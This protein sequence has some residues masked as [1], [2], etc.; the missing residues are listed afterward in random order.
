MVKLKEDTKTVRS[1]FIMSAMAVLFILASLIITLF[2][3]MPNSEIFSLIFSSLIFT[4]VLFVFVGLFYLGKNYK[5]TFLMKMAIVGFSLYL[6]LFI[7]ASHYPSDYGQRF[8]EFNDTITQRQANLEELIRLNV[9]EEVTNSL[10]L[11]TI[12]YILNTGLRLMLPLWLISIFSALYLTFLGISL[13]RL[14]KVKKTKQLGWTIIIGAWMIPTILGIMIAIPLLI[15][16]G[17]LIMIIF[18][19]ESKKQ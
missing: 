19:Q 12:S 8:I 13:M 17:I 5:K 3:K 11:E 1:Y 2:F 9:S 18:I 15:Y 7:S 16:A 14:E 10:E 4:S 6:I